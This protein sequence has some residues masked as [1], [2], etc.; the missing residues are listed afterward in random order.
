MVGW[1]V[2]WYAKAESVLNTEKLVGSGDTMCSREPGITNGS[3]YRIN[4]GSK[5][6]V[7]KNGSFAESFLNS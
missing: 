5:D 4:R 7:L 3:Q 6:A 2:K 1:Y